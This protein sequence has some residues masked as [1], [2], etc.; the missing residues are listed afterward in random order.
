MATVDLDKVSFHRGAVGEDLEPCP[1]CTLNESGDRIVT[2][3]AP[4]ERSVDV[5]IAFLT[6][7]LKGLTP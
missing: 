1:D 7:D 2:Y 4:C 3:C 6:G 5:M